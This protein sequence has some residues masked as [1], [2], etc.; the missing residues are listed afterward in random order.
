ML[1]NHPAKLLDN[2]GQRGTVVGIPM[3]P[4]TYL[5]NIADDGTKVFSVVRNSHGVGWG[6]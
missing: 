2:A 5:H 4:T 6:H 3:T 1:T